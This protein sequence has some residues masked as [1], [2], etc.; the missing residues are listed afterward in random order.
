MART[1][2]DAE[3]RR[4]KKLQG[5]I[6]QTT[7][8]LG[9]A[10]LGAFAASKVPAAKVLTKTP[11]LR[12]LAAGPVSRINPKKAENIALGTS[13]AAGGIGGAGAFNFASYTGAESKKRK[14][15]YGQPPSRVKK[16]L[17]MDTGYYGEEGHPIKLEEIKVPIEKAWSPSAS[18]FDS[19]A[20]RHKRTKVHE[21]GTAA[22]VGGGA[23]YAG[24]HGSKAAKESKGIKTIKYAGGKGKA[25]PVGAGA[26]A[27]KA[28]KHGGKALAGVAA[29]GAAAGLHSA[30]KRGKKSSWQSYA[31][32]STSA[33]GIDH[34]MDS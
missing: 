12:R 34:R 21:L 19:E 2:S 30:V 10:S 13:T 31:K 1:M 16:E 28:A 4:R 17:G 24:F 6:S 14:P 32:S 8:A 33:F 15:N 23:G 25:V 11:K 3:I 9:L 18:N 7:G 5:H 29:A 27:V 26:P 22:A 20:S